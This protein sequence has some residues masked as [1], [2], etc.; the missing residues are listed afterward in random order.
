[1]FSVPAPI[2][3]PPFWDLMVYLSKLIPTAP[4]ISKYTCVVFWGTTCENSTFPNLSDDFIMLKVSSFFPPPAT[5]PPKL[6]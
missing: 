1:M 6:R 5:L 4:V 2:L 3:T